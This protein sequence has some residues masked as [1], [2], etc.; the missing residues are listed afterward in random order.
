MMVRANHKIMNEKR[1]ILLEGRDSSLSQYW[2]SSVW[3]FTKPPMPSDIV[4]IIDPN[5]SGSE[6]VQGKYK[7]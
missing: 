5:Q 7:I 1:T 4:T 3:R 6:M 2:Q